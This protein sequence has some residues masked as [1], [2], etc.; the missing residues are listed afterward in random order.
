MG[1]AGSQTPGLSAASLLDASP[2]G[3]RRTTEA[4]LPAVAG[5]Q[6]KKFCYK[7]DQVFI[8]SD[9]YWQRISRKSARHAAAALKCLPWLFWSNSGLI[10]AP[11]KLLCPNNYWQRIS[12]KSARHAAAALKCLP[13]L[14]W[15]NSGLIGAPPK[16]LCPNNYWQR[17]SRKSARHAA[18]A[19]KCLPWL[20]W[21]NSGLIGAPPKLLCPNICLDL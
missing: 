19:L 13:W 10:G 21:S 8:N 12:R 7:V 18:A 14:F 20:F 6:A 16:L 4:F 11:P 2:P 1:S 17:I 5:R 3:F 15:S 9:I